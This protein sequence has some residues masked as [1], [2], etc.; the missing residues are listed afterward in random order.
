VPFAQAP[1]ERALDS[2]AARLQHALDIAFRLLN[3]RDRTVLEVRR[4]LEAK[5]VEP[6]VIERALAELVEQSYLDDARFA[7]RFAEDRRLLDEWGADRIERRLAALGVPAELV[8]DAVAARDAGDELDAAVALLR[9]RFPQLGAEP[10]EQ[11]RA[12]GVLVRKGYDVEL[13]W[14][15]IR[16]TIRA[17]NDWPARA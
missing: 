5:R 12:L 9:R 17:A 4:A 1:A 13:A 8:R 15:A 6:A 11:Q 7:Q 3:R 10:R 2:A 14:D 16:A